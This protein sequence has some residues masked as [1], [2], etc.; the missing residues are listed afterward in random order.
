LCYQ[1]D[2]DPRHQPPHV[3]SDTWHQTDRDGNSQRQTSDRRDKRGAWVQRRWRRASRV[4]LFRF[5]SL[6][7]AVRTTCCLSWLPFWC[8]WR[9]HIVQTS[10]RLNSRAKVGSSAPLCPV[11]RGAEPYLL[12]AVR[13]C[14]NF[15]TDR[16]ESQASSRTST[17][18]RGVRFGFSCLVLAWL[19]CSCCGRRSSGTGTAAD[20]S[21][22]A[23]RGTGIP[24]S[25]AVSGGGLW[26]WWHWLAGDY[27]RWGSAYRRE[28]TRTRTPRMMKSDP[29]TLSPGSPPR[30]GL[31]DDRRWRGHNPA[32]KTL[33]SRQY[34]GFHDRNSYVLMVA[35]VLFWFTS[36]W[37]ALIWHGTMHMG[38]G[39]GT[40]AARSH[41]VSGGGSY[42]CPYPWSASCAWHLPAGPS[43]SLPG[44]GSGI[45][46][47]CAACAGSLPP[48]WP[49]TLS[50][51]HP[52]V[53]AESCSHMGTYCEGRLWTDRP[54]TTACTRP[55]THWGR[56]RQSAVCH[57]RRFMDARLSKS[58]ALRAG[59]PPWRR[60]GPSPRRRRPRPSGRPATRRWAPGPRRERWPSS[61]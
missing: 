50:P 27:S 26:C 49:R 35:F 43:A 29:P 40:R 19:P 24:G 4:S 46:L 57:K 45:K 9:G 5:R 52:Q 54:R 37:P 23:G 61:R 58:T 22:T 39:G 2:D 10:Q 3:G 41:A 55:E 53:W 1:E 48:G 51:D 44:S 17:T 56:W 31:A 28:T 16:R 47:S 60:A 11:W 59:P 8:W 25:R 18:R 30:R 13:T 38:A 14:P 6:R 7:K 15:P 12:K 33:K 32:K 20:W 21:M 42:W 36:C 34:E